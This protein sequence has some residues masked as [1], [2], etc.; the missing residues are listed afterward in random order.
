M[1]PMESG[2]FLISQLILVSFSPVW[3]WHDLGNTEYH[4]WPITNPNANN[5][6]ENCQGLS[7]FWST[8]PPMEVRSADN[9]V[10][11]FT[12]VVEDAF[13]D[14]GIRNDTRYAIEYGAV[15]NP[16][17]YGTGA[18]AK[19][20]C[21][22]TKC[23]EKSDAKDHNCCLHHVNVHSCPSNMLNGGGICG[24][25]VPPDGD[26]FTH[27][28]S[29]VDSLN[30]TEWSTVVA[31]VPAGWTS[32]I[33][34]IRIGN[35]QAALHHKLNVKPKSVC[36]NGVCETKENETCS[37]CP[38]DCDRCP[39]PKGAVAAIA[40]SCVLVM[41][42]F[43]VVIG[44]FYW[45]QEKML[46]DESWIVNYDD[47]KPDTG[48]RGY[49][50]SVISVRTDNEASSIGGLASVAHQKQLFAQTGI[51]NGQTI[52]I[53]II[54][55]ISFALDK[56]IRK[57]VK[58]VR[59]IHHANLCKFMGGCV[60]VPNVAIATEYCPKGSLTDV[61]LND[62]VPLNWSFR[63]SFC[64]DIARG[65]NQLHSN[66]ICHGR[67]KSS[68]C[69][70]DDR[71]VVKIT[72]YG[73]PTFRRPDGNVEDETYN[74]RVARV[75]LPPEILECPSLTLTPPV[76]VYSFAVILVEI[77]TRNE[78]CDSQDLDNVDGR[79]RPS[80]PDLTSSDALPDDERCPCPEEY[81]KLIERCWQTNPTLRPTFSQIKTTIHSINPN[82]LSP[83]DMMMQLMEKY[84]RHLEAL[85]NER[86][87]D[88]ELEKQ[89]TDRLLYSMLP[90]PVADN[91]RQG[92]P[93]KAE[94]FESCTI[95]FSDIVGFT[96]LSSG[97]SPYEV[98]ALLNKL[99]VTFDSIIDAYDVY[100][101]E[102]IGDAYMVVSGIPKRN[103]LLHAGEIASMAIDLVQ[104]CETFI[105]PHRQ[106]MKLRIRAGIHSGSVVA[107]VVGLKMPR[108]CLFGD[109][110][111]TASRMESTGEALKIQASE[112]CVKILEVL[113]GYHTS[114]RGELP[115]K[116]KGIMITYWVEGKDQ[117]ATD[118]TQTLLTAT[119]VVLNGEPDKPASSPREQ[120]SVSD[121]NEEVNRKV[122]LP[123]S[124]DDR[125]V[126]EK[127]CL[128][129][130]SQV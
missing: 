25:W 84:S 22:N 59:D 3:A 12:I 67:L 109:T 74:S 36:G 128:I 81:K 34:H 60:D 97:S 8:E 104:V 100:K 48:L 49:T 82:K 9:F 111:N 19:K 127:S 16:T 35:L 6:L 43:C 20:W 78:P 68:N 24:P 91:L 80:L 103:G 130:E 66:R 73:L 87:Q 50:G 41:A 57:E 51:L 62:D 122:S 79:W 29:Q 39:L 83:V 15:F 76:D 113:G 30:H 89:K 105:I 54:N 47:I 38:A 7:M 46:W 107:G 77:A 55:K 69:V 86:T 120:L 106:D 108:Y 4:C 32:I 21:H 119:N 33:A 72:D 45:R 116:G 58:Q 61:L 93:S 94:S 88:L 110:V 95:F 14:W 99:Y 63:F 1:G 129:N 102:T 70:V 26:I 123:G 5:F 124:I 90:K 92:I 40:C 114:I 64:S 101:V 71:W 23:P 52:A 121:I 2:R 44:Y 17:K 117:P 13:F 27:T 11:N 53:K 10:V 28:E 18:A 31:L 65:M 85:V 98:V 112:A 96:S 126:T 56:R 125:D 118:S 37:T 42:V 115:V 75:Y